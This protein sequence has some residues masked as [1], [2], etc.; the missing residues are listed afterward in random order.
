[1]L[2]GQ[3]TLKRVGLQL[4]ARA[5]PSPRSEW[6]SFARRF[7]RDKAGLAGLVVIGVLLLAALFAPAIAPEDPTR[8]HVLAALAPPGQQYLLGTDEFGRDILS[9]IIWGSRI[10]L[11]VGLLSIALATVAGVSL[12]TLSGYYGGNADMLVMRIMDV[13]LAFPWLLLAI[14]V[15]SILGPGIFNAL[16]AVAIVYIPAFA[17]LVRGSVLSTKEQEFVLAARAAGASDVRIMTRHILVNVWGPTTVQATLSI[18]QA[19]IYAA[20]LSFIGLGTQPP[21]A[22]WGAMLSSG[23]E[24]LRQAPW[25]STFPGLA[26][27]LT[28]LAFN[29]F[30]DAFRDALDPRLGRA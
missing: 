27:M 28:V 19:I 3:A 10:S 23:R 4:A 6:R 5:E 15:M 22:D 7:V 1:M 30:G 25:V 20:A 8:Q 13:M 12:G 18:G 17:R 21:A 11:Q 26:I 9:R 24:Y 2:E 14:T 29:L 16:S